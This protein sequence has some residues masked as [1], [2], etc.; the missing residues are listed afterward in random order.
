MI[1]MFA[2]KAMFGMPRQQFCTVK[3][4]TF[5]EQVIAYFDRAASYTD[6]KP[7]KLK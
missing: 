1:Q 6:I 4:V 5:L 3:D 2:K 7:D